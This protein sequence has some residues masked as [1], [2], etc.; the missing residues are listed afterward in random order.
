[1]TWNI[2]PA[3]YLSLTLYTVYGVYFS[4]F[5]FLQA[6]F[7]WI[8]F[9]SSPLESLTKYLP[10]ALSCYA[11]ASPGCFC[12]VVICLLIFSQLPSQM[13]ELFVCEQKQPPPVYCFC[14]VASSASGTTASSWLREAGHQFTQHHLFCTYILSCSP[15]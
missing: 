10:R 3:L 13:Q 6:P 5:N 1:M 11:S 12:P 4:L 8:L 2:Q 14:W 7:L 9:Y 15:S